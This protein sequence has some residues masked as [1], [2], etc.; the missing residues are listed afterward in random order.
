MP[1]FDLSGV[2]SSLITLLRENVRQHIDPNIEPP[3][4]SVVG[5]PPERVGSQPNTLSIYLYHVAED[6]YYRNAVG[7]GNDAVN[8]ARTPMA[9]SLYYILTAHHEVDSEFDALAQQRLMGYA[10]KTLH[11]YPVITDNTRIGTTEVLD[12]ALR[13]RDNH[14]QIVLRPV[15][16]EDALSFWTTEDQHTARLAAYYEVR[17]VMLEPEPPRRFPGV[18][19]NVGTFVVQLGAPH[20]DRSRNFVGF[21]LPASAGGG[22]QQ[23]E[24]SPARAALDTSGS[25][26]HNALELLGTNLARGLRQT[27]V[28]DTARWSRRTPPAV[29]VAVDPALNAAAGWVVEVH[30]ERIAVQLGAP[31]RFVDAAGDEVVLDVLPGL[32]AASLRVVVDEQVLAGQL[33]QITT[34]SNAVG[35]MIA[36]RIASHDPPDADG[37][38]TVALEPGFA[39]DHGAG[40]PAEEPDV[41][42]VIDGQAYQR[43]TVFEPLPAENAGRFTVAAASFTLQPLFDTAQAGIHALRLLVDGAESQPFWIEVS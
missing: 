5:Q 30:P 3:P 31:L 28:L 20:L 15:T 6:P 18:V 41:Q 34:R 2:T 11:D 4:L 22:S 7:P 23:I 1:L 10:L 26:P 25:P 39:L 21:S 35:L 40:D 29:A 36:P 17:V 12:A 14:L 27:L 24:V 19:L 42:L 16:P 38:I 8:V 37:R 9:L 32:Y 43:V 33:R 13:G